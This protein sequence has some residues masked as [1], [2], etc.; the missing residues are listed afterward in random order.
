M[1]NCLLPHPLLPVSQDVIPVFCHICSHK[2]DVLNLELNVNKVLGEIIIIIIIFMSKFL[3]LSPLS[4]RKPFLANIRS[5][6]ITFSI[7]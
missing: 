1:S 3:L 7:A 5:L 2:Y 6:T 4:E